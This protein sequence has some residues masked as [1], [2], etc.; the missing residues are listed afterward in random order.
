MEENSISANKVYGLMIDHKPYN[1]GHQFIK[2]IEVRQLGSIPNDFKIYLKVNGPG[3]D[4][5]IENETVVDLGKSGREQF[6]SQVSHHQIT[7]MVNGKEKSW[8]EPTITFVQV[9]ILAFGNYVENDNV[10]YTVT[11]AKGPVVNLEGTMVKG[12]TVDVKQKMIFNVTS[13]N[14]S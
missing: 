1:W 8:N 13:T 12:D 3:E 14:R 9:V 5:L 4:E 7:L 10:I 11:Y 2:G 6:Y